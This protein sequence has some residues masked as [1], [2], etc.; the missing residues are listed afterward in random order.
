M[1][2]AQLDCEL[3]VTFN[4]TSASRTLR[5]KLAR[6]EKWGMAWEK[7]E[8]VHEIASY[9]LRSDS[10]RGNAS[11][12]LLA[13]GDRVA[14]GLVLADVVVQ[15]VP[16]LRVLIERNDFG[17]LVFVARA[18]ER[19]VGSFILLEP[20]A[21]AESQGKLVDLASHG[22][23]HLGNRLHHRA[24]FLWLLLLRLLLLRL[25]TASLA[26]AS[27]LRAWSI[28]VGQSTHR[29]NTCEYSTKSLIVVV[30]LYKP[31]LPA[32]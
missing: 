2:L 6:L 1:K 29:S 11:T 18:V 30:C 3:R 20:L 24:L 19:P 13:S 31:Y 17:V 32:T 12:I 15:A 7:K 5:P 25:L 9:S 28:V 21:L 22:V 8:Y 27:L 16:A 23:A 10:C 14:R 26:C 4:R